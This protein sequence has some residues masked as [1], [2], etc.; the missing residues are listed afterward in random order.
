MNSKPLHLWYAYPDDLLDSVTAQACAALLTPQENE[1]WRRYKYEKN[2]R[3]FL[4]T[5]ALV[6]TALSHDRAVGPE[7]WRF[8]ENEHGKPFLEPDCGLQFNLSNSVGLVVCVIAEGIQV[9]V[10]VESEARSPNILTV[11]ER[12]FSEAER[13][14][15]DGLQYSAKLD[16]VLSLWTLKEAYIKARGMG[17]ALPLEKISFLFDGADGIRLEIDP[18][19]ESNPGRWRFCSFDHCDHRIA[20]VVE[21]DKIPEMSLWAAR[22]LLAP[23][24]HLG[25]CNA[26][27]F[28][29]AR[30]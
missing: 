28:P 13:A 22:P 10:D 15:L 14:Q 29:L 12:V 25:P 6:R 21:E 1:R 8:R 18:D 7:T 17:L 24:L 4:A 23:P 2:Q 19:L 3:E 26:Q 11:V 5:R 27:W 20:V 30:K 16:R 9:G